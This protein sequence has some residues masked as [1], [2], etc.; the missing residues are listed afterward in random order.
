MFSCLL[1][2]AWTV[3]AI[4]CRDHIPV[5]WSNSFEY[6]NL[7]SLRNSKQES[8]SYIKAWWPDL[9]NKMKNDIA[10]A[11]SGFSSK[12][13]INE[14]FSVYIRLFTISEKLHLKDS[15]ATK[16]EVAIIYLTEELA[17]KIDKHISE[18]APRIV[19][20]QIKQILKEKS[21]SWDIKIKSIEMLSRET[22]TS[23]SRMLYRVRVNYENNALMHSD[24]LNIYFNWSIWVYFRPQEWD[25][26]VSYIEKNVMFNSSW[27]TLAWTLSYPKWNG[28]FPTVLLIAWSW[29][30]NR[31][32]YGSRH[33]MFSVI[34]DVL[35][36][37]GYAVLRY[38]KRWVEWSSWKAYPEST[39]QDYYDDA[40]AWFEFL[41]NQSMVDSQRIWAIWHS[42]WWII[43]SM[44]ASKNPDIRFL[45]LLA[46]PWQSIKEI[47]YNQKLTEANDAN[48][49]LLKSNYKSILDKIYPILSSDGTRDQALEKLVKIENSMSLDERIFFWIIKKKLPFWSYEDMASP[50]FRHFLTLDIND[51]LPKIRCPILAIAWDKDA[52]V[53]AEENIEKIRY[54]VGKWWNTALTTAILPNTWHMFERTVSFGNAEYNDASVTF[55][56]EWLKN[57]T[58]WLK[59]IE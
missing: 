5:F 1:L 48:W 8:V 13:S 21:L 34:S 46:T 49:Q 12:K 9:S 7:C 38:D 18:N 58:D 53:L 30:N 16:K 29:P 25:Y 14:I 44:L 47:L 4:D 41:K 2:S 54:A 36:K 23:I 33:R 19:G 35:V 45:I 52:N 55:S 37:N 24:I 11:V 28:K 51:Y 17:S 43:A 20:S 40:N 56:P 26:P 10:N 57:I 31:D 22:H 59:S 6:D 27:A 42:E 39:T 50:W 15:P 32:V 3:S